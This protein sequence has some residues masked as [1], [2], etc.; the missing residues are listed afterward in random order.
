M[1]RS[2]VLRFIFV[3]SLCLAALG[4]VGS[5]GFVTAQ[6]A[7]DTAEWSHV[8]VA[9]VPD[10]TDTTP[11][12]YDAYTNGY[13]KF[14]GTATG[15]LFFWCNVVSPHEVMGENPNWNR[16]YVTFKDSNNQ[17]YVEVRLIRKR[18]DNGLYAYNA[19][20]T[21]TDGVGVREAAAPGALPAFDFETYAYFVRVQLHR[22]T[23]KGDPQFHIVTLRTIIE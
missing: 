2:Q 6:T 4:L 11:S 19:T 5:A 18:K 17:G 1:K 14:Q 7:F 22:D 10:D 3:L 15:D 13:L 23:S 16:M 9:C 20:F 8:G 12:R 21:S